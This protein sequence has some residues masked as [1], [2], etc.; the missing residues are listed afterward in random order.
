VRLILAYCQLPSLQNGIIHNDGGKTAYTPGENITFTCNPGYESSVTSTTCRSSESWDPQPSCTVITCDIPHLQNGYY[1]PIGHPVVPLQSYGHIIQPQCNEGY[2]LS[3]AVNKTCTEHGQWSGSD[4]Q[5][6]CTVVSCSIPSLQNGFYL[7]NG[8]KA[9][10]SQTYDQ[11][12][13]P[14]C[15]P[16]Y[17]ITNE[18]TRTCTGS[19]QWSGSDP[20]CIAITCNTLPYVENGHYDVGSHV[21]PFS[22]NLSISLV[23]DI[24]FKN[25]GTNEVRQCKFKD[26]WSGEYTTCIRVTCRQPD[27]YD[28]GTYNTSENRYDFES[29]IFPTCQSGFYM[30]N[31]VTKRVCIEMNKW[32]ESKPVCEIF[33]CQTPIVSNG[34]VVPSVNI[35]NY[36]TSITIQCNAGFEIKEGSHIR[37]CHE[38]GT[39][40]PVI[41]QCERKSCNDSVD[42][43]LKAVIAFP[44][45]LLFGDVGHATYNANIF[46][47]TRGSTEVTC[48]PEKKFTWKSTPDFGMIKQF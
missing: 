10:Q 19:G 32:S 34:Y 44:S 12:I 23:C 11:I 46:Y 15:G 48:S 24:G 26:A 16:G 42:V 21:L 17:T 45:I 43:D 47:L 35:Y 31:N 36:N 2:I 1:L 4:P 8:D 29:V 25:N 3:N 6:S 33:K 18:N 22:Y 9:G 14:Q 27:A 40:D 41:S 13:Q 39:W 7:H 20:E 28:H 30:K 5:P 38:K 37:T